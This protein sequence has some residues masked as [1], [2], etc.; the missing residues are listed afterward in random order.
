[1]KMG[2]YEACLEI[3]QRGEE[4]WNEQPSDIKEIYDDWNLKLANEGFPYNNKYYWVGLILGL[5]CKEE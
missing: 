2:Y 3:I 4:G 5:N 1:M